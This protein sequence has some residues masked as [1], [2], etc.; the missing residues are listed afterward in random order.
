MH[1]RIARVGHAR[2]T[3]AVSIEE[4]RPVGLVQHAHARARVQR[5]VAIEAG[6]HPQGCNPVVGMA[7]KLRVD[8]E[9][10][11][12]L[13]VLAGELQVLEGNSETT[14]QVIDLHQPCAPVLVGHSDL[15][16]PA[17]FCQ[18]LSIH[19]AANPRAM[20]RGPLLAR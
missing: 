12:S 11:Q 2:A 1:Q 19:L 15:P 8:Q 13:G 18:A 7:A 5:A 14:S 6:Q 4:D 9:C 20:L 16:S 17:L 3:S 10:A